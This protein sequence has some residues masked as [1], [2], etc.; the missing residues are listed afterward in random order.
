MAFWIVKTDPE[1][2]SYADLERDGET[3]WDGVK[4]PQAL[5]H[6]GS[7]AP[8][9]WLFVYHSGGERAMVGTARIKSRPYP[10]P[11]GRDA[12]LLVVD[13]VAEARLPRPVTLS[14]LKEDRNF[15]GSPL[16]RQGRLSVIP[17]TPEQW[18]RVLAAAKSPPASAA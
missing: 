1:A 12:K 15:A 10:D 13:I 3:V 18:N 14:E 8:G 16:L 17:V 5:K 7:M 4:N 2:Y 11:K 6:L 9:D